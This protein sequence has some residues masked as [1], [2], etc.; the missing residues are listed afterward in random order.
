MKDGARKERKESVDIPASVV[1]LCG[2]LC[3]ATLPCSINLSPDVTCLCGMTS[4]G[5]RSAPASVELNCSVLGVLLDVLRKIAI[6]HDLPRWRLDGD[7]K[8]S[9]G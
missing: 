8:K 7:R 9:D 3:E 1:I 6:W 5:D 4:T 2:V